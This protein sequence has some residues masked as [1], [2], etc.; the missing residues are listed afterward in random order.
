MGC[1]FALLAA[2]SSFTV[3]LMPRGNLSHAGDCGPP[4]WARKTKAAVA[5]EESPEASRTEF[6][7]LSAGCMCRLVICGHF[8]G[9]L[10]G[11]LQGSAVSISA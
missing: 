6:A 3:V 11:E 9:K 7:R 1:L 4:C 10:L 8:A 5:V 2:L